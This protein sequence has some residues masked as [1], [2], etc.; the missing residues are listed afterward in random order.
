MSEGKLREQI[1]RAAQAERL[2]RDPILLEA[3]EK[4][5]AE[6]LRA[7]RGTNVDDTAARE[8]IYMLCQSLEAVRTHLAAVVTDGKIAKLNLEK[9]K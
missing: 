3:F 9:L 2:M 8:R 5:D 6:F 1:D 4:L 7:W